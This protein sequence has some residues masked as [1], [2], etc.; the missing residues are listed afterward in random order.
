MEEMDFCIQPR[1][2]STWPCFLM[3]HCKSLT[4]Y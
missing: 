2:L 1:Q 3:G 4:V